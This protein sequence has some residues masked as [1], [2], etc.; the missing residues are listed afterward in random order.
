[1]QP[2]PPGHGQT[3]ELPTSVLYMSGQPAKRTGLPEQAPELSEG[4]LHVGEHYLGPAKT[5]TLRGPLR[6]YA[7]KPRALSNR[8][9]APF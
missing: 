6:T 1:M 2:E 8:N 5:Y 7:I 9:R 4:D 3:G